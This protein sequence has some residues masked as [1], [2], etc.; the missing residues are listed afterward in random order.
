MVLR[1]F[2]SRSPGARAEPQSA[3]SNKL[4]SLFMAGSSCP[5]DC[6]EPWPQSRSCRFYFG[7]RVTGQALAM[8]QTERM[9]ELLLLP[10]G[11]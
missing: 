2:G 11:P 5:Q 8:D 3:Q 10:P 9:R 4:R 6:P 1:V 7:G